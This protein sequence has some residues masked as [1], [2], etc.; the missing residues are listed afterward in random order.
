MA[1]EAGTSLATL[2][3]SHGRLPLR[4]V[5]T[6]SLQNCWPDSCRNQAIR[7]GEATCRSARHK[8]VHNQGEGHLSST[9]AHC[10]DAQSCLALGCSS[11]HTST[12]SVFYDT[13]M[14]SMHFAMQCKWHVLCPQK[15]ILHK[16]QATVI[17][18]RH[19]FRSKCTARKCPFHASVLMQV[20]RRGSLLEIKS[21]HSRRVISQW[22]KCCTNTQTVSFDL[23]CMKW[24]CER[25]LNLLKRE[26][27]N[28]ISTQIS[29]FTT[30][31]CAGLQLKTCSWLPQHQVRCCRCSFHWCCSMWT[32]SNT[33]QTGCA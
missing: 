31:I 33:C 22:K 16:C 12:D 24:C 14:R 26:K 19:M 17:S 11:W 18:H 20:T 7:V 8:Q 2:M 25:P 23:N 21:L 3:E 1:K 10:P 27:P 28:L 32:A 29:T 4:T 5:D 15:Y 30:T 6:A 13:A 9:L